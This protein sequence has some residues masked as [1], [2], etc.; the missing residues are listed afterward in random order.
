MCTA[1]GPTGLAHHRVLQLTEVDG[2]LVGEVVED[3]VRL[4]RLLPQLL[5]AEDQVHLNRWASGAGV[6]WVVS[7][8]QAGRTGQRVRL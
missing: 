6:H 1:D 2:A 5:V 7:T 3:V 8:L 4:L